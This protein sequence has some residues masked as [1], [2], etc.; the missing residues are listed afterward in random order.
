MRALSFV[1][2]SLLTVATACAAPA[3]R[4]ETSL[5]PR[6]RVEALLRAHHG[7]PERSLIEEAGAPDAA[8]ILRGI[9]ADPQAFMPVRGAAFEALKWWPDEH[10]LA[11]YTTA[12]GA[13]QPASLRHRVLRYLPVYG[14][15][16]LPLL[17]IALGDANPQIRLT[18]AYAAFDTPG[19]NA[20]K[21]L[22]DTAASEADPATRDGM[23][24]LIAKRATIR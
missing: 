10:T 17:T 15:A 3:A 22:S 1:L 2:V 9:A 13:D 20:A 7:L 24:Q 18:A 19:A 8:K 14:E 6:A 16:A 12:V 23:Q 21:L 5:T 4:P 11:L